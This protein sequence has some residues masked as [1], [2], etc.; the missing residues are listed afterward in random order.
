[1]T[2]DAAFLYVGIFATGVMIILTIRYAVR[3]FDHYYPKK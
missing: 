1:M 2:K 3:I